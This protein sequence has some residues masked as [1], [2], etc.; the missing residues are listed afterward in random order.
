[1]SYFIFDCKFQTHQISVLRMHGQHVTLNYIQTGEDAAAVARDLAAGQA[2]LGPAAQ[3]KSAGRRRRR[4]L[5]HH[6]GRLDQRVSV[7]VRG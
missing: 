7:P 5:G 2:A 4:R 1:M 6:H 3:A